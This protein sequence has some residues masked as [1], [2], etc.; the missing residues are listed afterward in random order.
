VLL[1]RKTFI[2]DILLYTTIIKYA[3]IVKTI[4]NL[5]RIICYGIDFTQSA[6]IKNRKQNFFKFIMVIY[7]AIHNLCHKFR[8]EI[9]V[10]TMICQK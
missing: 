4:R 6:N 8:I 1:L 7:M 9:R 10:E 2:Q 5:K 3:D